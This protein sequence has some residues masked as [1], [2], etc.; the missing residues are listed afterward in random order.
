MRHARAAFFRLGLAF[1]C[2]EGLTELRIG[3]MPQFLLLIALLG[4]VSSTGFLLLVMAAARRFRSR[5][6]ESAGIHTP[7][8]D[9]A[10]PQ[11]NCCDLVKRG[12]N[13][14]VLC[15]RGPNTPKTAS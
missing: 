14:R 10:A 12:R 11:V 15:V 13:S 2:G 9:Q 3:E 4:L 5:A 8:K 1:S 6:R 7:S